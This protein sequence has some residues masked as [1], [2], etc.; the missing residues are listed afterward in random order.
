[1]RSLAALL[2]LVLPAVPGLAPAAHAM[3][4]GGCTITGTINFAPGPAGAE[5]GR[6]TIEPAVISC[7]G[8]FR[9]KHRITGPGAFIGS[10]TYAEVSD[11]TGTCLHSI[12][13][14][15][16][17]YLIP[18]SEATVRIQ[19]PHEFVFAGAGAFTT[20]SLRGTFEGT[21]PYDGDC[22]TEPVTRA[23]FVAQALM[24]R[25]NGLDH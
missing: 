18:T 7:Q 23:T 12:G 10:G 21:P 25:L 16:V 5:R 19:E 6:W 24:L 22:V 4:A 2:G 20:P 15:Q 8:L 3:G 14:G 9:A 11:G 13:S 17:D 1:M